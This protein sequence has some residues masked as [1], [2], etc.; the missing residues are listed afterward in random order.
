MKPKDIIRT[1]KKE[2]WEQVSSRGSHIKFR[3]GN[4][5]TIVAYHNKDLKIKTLKTIEKQTGIKFT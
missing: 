3:K 5:I 1:L 2:G 4:Q